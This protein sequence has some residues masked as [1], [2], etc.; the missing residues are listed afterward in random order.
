VLK[1][2]REVVQTVTGLFPVHREHSVAYLLAN[3]VEILQWLLTKTVSQVTGVASAALVSLLSVHQVLR[4][5]FPVQK[6]HTPTVG[7]VVVVGLL[8]T[9]LVERVDKHNTAVVVIVDRAVK[10]ALEW[11]ES[12]T[13]KKDYQWQVIHHTKK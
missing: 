10:A 7:F 12:L 6:I 3:G 2:V 1:V 8:L 5:W 13:S 11:Y 4:S 9:Q